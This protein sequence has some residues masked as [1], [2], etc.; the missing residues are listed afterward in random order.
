MRPLLHLAKKLILFTAVTLLVLEALVRIF[1]LYKDTPA[2]FV[3][4]R[5]VEKWRPGQHGYAVTGNR[6][7]NFSEYRIN[8]SGYNSAREYTP[9]ADTLEIALVGDSFIEGFHQDYQA[10][11]GRKMEARLPGVQVY[12]YGYAGYDLADELHLL[13]AYREDFQN[14]DYTLIYLKFPDDLQ[15]STYQVSYDR[16]RLETGPYRLLKMSK[17]VVYL[18][19]IGL[20][21]AAR[22]AVSQGMAALRPTPPPAGPAPAPE[23]QKARYLENLQ[24]LLEQYPV[25]TTKTAFLLDSRNAPEEVL[26][27]LGQQG[28][29]Y[30]DYGPALAGSATPVTLIYDQHWNDHGREILA[31]TLSAWVALRLRR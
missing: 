16:L 10:S 15:R 29:A 9:D 7:Q 28:I 5:E 24:A 13:Q 1:H 30:L 26:H 8:A 14:I 27:I 20:M 6:R 2:R 12:E 22:N 3:D 25:D 19:N 21:S 23:A 11:I 17:L 31:D 18:Q 4:A